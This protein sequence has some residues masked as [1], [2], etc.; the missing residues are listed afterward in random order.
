[1]EY[2]KNE[3]LFFNDFSSAFSKLLEIGVPAFIPTNLDEAGVRNKISR[4][5]LDSAHDYG[6]WGPLFVRLAWHSSGTYDPFSNITGGS[7]GATM[8][9]PPESNDPAN[10]GIIAAI[11]RLQ[12]IKS[13]TNMSLADI[14][15]LAGVV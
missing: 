3:T 1:M 7:N 8:R 4:L 6:S 15:T 5:L 10:K 13:M 12:P 14:W 9:F 11:N 2:A